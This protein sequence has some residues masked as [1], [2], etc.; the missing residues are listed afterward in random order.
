[1]ASERV[2]SH[3]SRRNI[4]QPLNPELDGGSWREEIKKGQRKFPVESSGGIGPVI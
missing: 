1:V 4:S 3:L 2:V